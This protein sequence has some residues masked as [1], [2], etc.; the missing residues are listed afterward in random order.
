MDIQATV[1]QHWNLQLKSASGEDL[2]YES[3]VG[4]VHVPADS[5][6]GV[7]RLRT[8]PRWEFLRSVVPFVAVAV[9]QGDHM[10][11]EAFVKDFGWARDGDRVAL[12]FVLPVMGEDEYRGDFTYSLAVLGVIRPPYMVSVED[13]R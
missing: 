13:V 6:T 3:G 4:T 8:E 11:N 1:D 7:C 5:D 10:V 12:R 9:Y 2:Y